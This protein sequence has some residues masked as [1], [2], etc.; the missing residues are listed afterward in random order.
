MRRLM[1]LAVLVAAWGFSAAIR[2]Q[3]PAAAQKPRLLDAEKLRDNLFVLRHTAESEDS[4]GNTAVFITAN[5]VVVVDTKNPRW[6][7]P[8]LDKIRELTDKPV[9]TI[10]NTHTHGDHVSGNVEFPAAVEVIVQENTAANMKKMTGAGST[11]EKPAPS[12]F[13]ANG[14]RGLPKRTF[15]D[16]MTIGKGADQ[17]DLYYFG[18][19]HTN[20]DAWIVFTNARVMHAGDIF[21]RKNIPFIDAGNGG[22]G[23]QI[24]DTLEKAAKGV[25]N[26]DT[27]ITGHSVQMTIADLQQYAEFNRDF[28]AFVQAGKKNGKS[29]DEIAAGWQAPARY[30]GYGTPDAARLKGNI[31]AILNELK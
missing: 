8:I 4:G 17:I 12:I 18:R 11:A 15:K 23:V 7:K 22:S 31:E 21:A 20:G 3:Q 14:G 19:G 6:G 24:G 26:V 2:A 13:H 10:I 16:K 30:T 25:R 1:V 9:T 29:V 27:I 28:L 5:G